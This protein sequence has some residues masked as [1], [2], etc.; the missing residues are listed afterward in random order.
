MLLTL[1]WRSPRKHGQDDISDSS[2]D[3]NRTANRASVRVALMQQLV[4]LRSLAVGRRNL[5]L[6]LQSKDQD[7]PAPAPSPSYLMLRFLVPP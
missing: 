6:L 5:T 7:V 1:T 2:H 4:Q 3:G